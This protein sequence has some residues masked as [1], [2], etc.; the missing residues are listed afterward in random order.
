M[1]TPAV[2]ETSGG[3][4]PGRMYPALFSWMECQVMKAVK[5]SLSASSGRRC[6]YSA[7]AG[8]ASQST[9]MNCVG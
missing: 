4:M 3:L 9:R 7:K 8:A 2:R 5:L 6:V 1:K